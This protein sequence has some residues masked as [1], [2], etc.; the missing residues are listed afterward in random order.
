MGSKKSACVHKE[1]IVQAALEEIGKYGVR[2]LTIAAIADAAGMSKTNFY[3]HFSEKEEIFFAIADY[4][5]S[6]IMGKAETIAESDGKPLGKL[7][8][9]FFSHLNLVA[10]QPGIPRFVFSEDIQLCNSKLAGTVAFLIG[11]YVKIVSGIV[12]AGIAEGELK[13]DLSPRQTAL[14]LI[15]TIQFTALRWTISDA[16][17]DKQ[18]EIEELWRNFSLLNRV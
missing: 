13:Q 8:A 7:E 14:T 15:G 6:A 17:F 1:D 16:S 2:Q 5:G 11:T 3:R 9:I 12:A 4:I 10:K 18:E